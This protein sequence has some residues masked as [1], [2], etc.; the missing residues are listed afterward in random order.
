[1]VELGSLSCDPL[2]G[3]LSLYLRKP[4]FRV[5]GPEGRKFEVDSNRRNGGC[6]SWV[7]VSHSPAELLSA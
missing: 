4:N 2:A 3:E 7:W 5:A 6:S 1:M